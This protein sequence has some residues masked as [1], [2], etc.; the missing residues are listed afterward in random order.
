MEPDRWIEI[1]PSEYA[2]ELE[3]LEYLK[4][5]LPDGEPF[6]A[7]SNFEFIAGDGSINEVDLL[8]VSLHKVYLVEIKSWSG[9]IS[10]DSNTWRR[11][12]GGREFLVDNPL[13]L[14]NRK[15]K[16]LGSILTAQKA[17]AKK[18]RPF[19]EAVVFLSRM[20]VR[21]SL[22]GRAR[23]GVHVSDSP[24]QSGHPSI[25][26][27]LSGNAGFDPRRPPSRID[28]SLSRAFGQAMKQAG[29]RPS[30]RQRRVADYRIR[31]LLLETDTYQD[32]EAE[33]I[34]VPSSKRR[35]R[36]YPLRHA[37]SESTRAE[38]RL[39]AEREYKLLDG[40]V[41]DGI[42]RVELLTDAEQG[43]ALVFEHDPEAERLDHFLE[44]RGNDGP[45]LATRLDLLRQLAEALKYAH[46]R[47]VFHRAL[48]PQKVLVLEPDSA[49]PKLKVFD[50]RTGL[51]DAF[52][53]SRAGR[54]RTPATLTTLG[55][56][57]DDQADVYLAPE[58]TQGP[59]LPEKLDIFS[60][61]AIGYRLL[62]GQPPAT[63][64]VGL[65][66]RL[67]VAGG[68]QLSDAV[69]GI[70]E[71]LQLVIEG[72]TEPEVSQRLGSVSEF[73]MEA[74]KAGRAVFLTSD[75][76]H[77]LEAD[78]VKLPGDGEGRWR[79]AAT[80]ATEPEIEIGGARVRAATGQ[81]RIILPWSETV[82]YGSKRNG[83]HG[84]VTLQEAVVP[85]GVYVGPG[86][87]LE[88]WE[89]SPLAYP[90]WWNKDEPQRPHVRLPMAEL[91]EPVSPSAPQPDLFAV[92]EHEQ[93]ASAA[94]WDRLFGSD[95]YAAQRALAAKG[96]PDDDAVRAALDALYEADGRLPVP[97]LAKRLGVEPP[98]ARRTIDGLQRLL[99]VDGLPV[100]RLNTD[101][102]HLDL[103]VALLV[104]RF[105]LKP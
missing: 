31:E 38:R 100:L 74:Y 35:V 43:P 54:E 88:G 8:V 72:A 55:L 93:P 89:P 68:L 29:V 9:T 6:R 10:G 92:A 77:V 20:G 27:I 49:R 25:L 71:S 103:D 34:S 4:A 41:H 60:L 101:G 61:G 14:A 23:T 65:F 105:E 97:T 13:L 36:I 66:D 51:H 26:D 79:S 5:R 86:E 21:C 28:P 53:R 7:W 99:N 18:R 40:I 12:V 30:Q 87:V 95:L 2:W 58:T 96:A 45:D 32:W 104:G 42:L 81:E 67:S 11:E 64:V 90:S 52:P 78:G 50:W 56:S 1:T 69:D 59:Y 46:E 57:G 80:P 44:R 48:S 63:T 37:S 16:K 17:L 39:T 62:G 47:R 85:V 98:H 91:V 82:R 22:E 102:E 83:Y 19:I 76:G 73:L 75:H 15:A 33:H 3:A 84:G 24:G 94:R 70:H